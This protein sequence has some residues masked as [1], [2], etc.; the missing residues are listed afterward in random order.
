MGLVLRPRA[1]RGRGVVL[2]GASVRARAVNEELVAQLWD[3]NVLARVNEQFLSLQVPYGGFRC[4]TFL[5][6]PLAVKYFREFG[7]A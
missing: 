1:V 6:G 3:A 5:T 2:R 4:T 7:I